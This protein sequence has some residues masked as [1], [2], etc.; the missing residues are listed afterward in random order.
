[1]GLINN[2]GEHPLNPGEISI[3][4]RLALKYGLETGDRLTLF[5]DGMDSEFTV[6]GIFQN[7]DN[8]GYSFR[9]LDRTYIPIRPSYTP[10]HYYVR[11]HDPERAEEVLNDMESKYGMYMD[12]VLTSRTIREIERDFGSTMPY[13]KLLFGFIT[14]VFFLISFTIIHNNTQDFILEYR[15]SLGILKAL[16]LSPPGLRSIGVYRI[17]I[18]LGACL[19][20]G[21]PLSILLSPQLLNLAFHSSGFGAFPPRP[22]LGDLLWIVPI[23][24]A[25]GFISSWIPMGQT[26]EI[27]TRELIKGE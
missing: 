10:A 22:G 23:I 14:A 15:R 25:F 4:D 21:F 24:T 5:M 2:E 8:L 3:T 26:G 12:G 20:V 19:I 17:L 9:M 1:M 18:L 11:L 13:V 27:Q 7:S 6:S 16:G